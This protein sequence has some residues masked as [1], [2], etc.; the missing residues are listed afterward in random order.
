MA[1]RSSM[2][3]PRVQ[4]RPIPEMPECSQEISGCSNRILCCVPIDSWRNTTRVHRSSQVVL[5]LYPEIWTSEYWLSV[6]DAT[7]KH[8]LSQTYKSIF[9]KILCAL[10]GR[11]WNLICRVRGSCLRLAEHLPGPPI[12]RHPHNSHGSSLDWA[13]RQETSKCDWGRNNQALDSQ[14]LGDFP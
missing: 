5:E 6:W 14:W 2:N 10:S 12:S 8:T 4:L 1:Q 13:V 3:L 7:V 9:H 11:T